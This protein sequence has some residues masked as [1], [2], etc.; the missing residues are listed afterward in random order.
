M[1]LAGLISNSTGGLAGGLTGGLALAAAALS[2]CF[3][4][5]SLIYGFNVFHFN[6]FLSL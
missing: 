5:I 2:R 6:N 3:L 4:K 1:S